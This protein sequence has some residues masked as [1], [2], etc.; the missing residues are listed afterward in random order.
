MRFLF[1]STQVTHSPEFRKASELVSKTQTSNRLNGFHSLPFSEVGQGLSPSVAQP[2]PS[3]WGSERWNGFPKVTGPALGR[4]QQTPL[5]Q[6][7]LGPIS[8]AGMSARLR[9]VF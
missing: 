9:L 7:C 4:S 8:S 5:P 6:C 3:S 2:A 1:P